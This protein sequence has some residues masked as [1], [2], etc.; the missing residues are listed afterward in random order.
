MFPCLSVE[1]TRCHKRIGFTTSPDSARTHWKQTVF[2]LRDVL[3]VK[4]NEKV[5]G[6]FGMRPNV[7]NERDIDFKIRVPIYDL[8]VEQSYTLRCV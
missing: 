2:Y 8:M 5:A 1:F 3:T 4:R 6:S 7:R